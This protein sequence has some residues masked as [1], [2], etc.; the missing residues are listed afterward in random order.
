VLERWKTLTGGYSQG[1]VLHRADGTPVP[2]P[3][4]ENVFDAC[5]MAWLDPHKR[6]GRDAVAT[7][8]ARYKE[9]A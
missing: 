1:N 4:E 7:A 2:T 6:T 8:V 5:R 3:E 9:A